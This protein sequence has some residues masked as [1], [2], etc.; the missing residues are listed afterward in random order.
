MKILKGSLEIFLRVNEGNDLS[1]LD[2][3][4]KSLFAQRC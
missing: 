4:K 2:N 1:D 3:I